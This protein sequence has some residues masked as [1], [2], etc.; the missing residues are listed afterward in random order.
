MRLKKLEI[1]GFKTFCEK[2]VLEFSPGISGVIGPNGCGKSN[3]VDAIR[4]VMGEQRIKALRGKKMDDVIFSGAENTAPV[5]MAE[6]TMTMVSDGQPFS[7]AYGECSELTIAR[8]IF[9]EGESEY[10]LN[11]VP[12]RLLDVKEFFMD[13]GVG[14]RTYSLVE[15]NSVSTL[16]EAKPEERR[17]YIEE[18]A[19]I[20]KYKSRKEAALRK[21][22]ATRQN[23]LRLHD[24]MKEVKTQL[25]V[26]SR[27]AKRA[28]LYRALKKEI[29]EAEL[30]LALVNYA[31]LIEKRAALEKDREILQGK[32]TAITTEL[33]GREAS[34]EELKVTVMQQEEMISQS[35]EKLYEIKNVINMKEQTV[36][37]SRKRVA[38]LHAQ[39]ERNVAEIETREG[40]LA[41]IQNEVHTLTAQIETLQREIH[42]VQAAILA[43]QKQLDELRKADS[44]LNKESDARKV[45]YIDI[46][47]EKSKLKNMEANFV[48][49]LE[50][51]NLFLKNL[52]FFKKTFEFLNKICFYN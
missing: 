18:A 17:Q 8:R 1:S 43:N 3:I 33:K 34:F 19:G 11:K 14:A 22:E 16:V 12:C 46:A 41:D 31:D 45:A 38:D 48:K 36:E 21:M 51:I 13:T 9:R 30:S 44:D 28:E 15:Q 23:M 27:Q 29:K 10:Y 20:A 47:A 52:F 49:T 26:V 6:V 2:V 39:K 24:I 40:R 50:A 7:G 37:F 4:W 35:R 25:N 42:D 32:E 5:G